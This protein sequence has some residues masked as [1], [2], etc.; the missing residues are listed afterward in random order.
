MNKASYSGLGGSC[1]QESLNVT[2]VRNGLDSDIIII[3]NKEHLIAQGLASAN[4]R[5]N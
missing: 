4:D 2:K 1:Y 5:E 3:E